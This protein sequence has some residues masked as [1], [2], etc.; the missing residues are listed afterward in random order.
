MYLPLGLK[1]I[2]P[3]EMAKRRLI[4]P[5]GKRGSALFFVMADPLNYRVIYDMAFNNR[6]R[7]SPSISDEDSVVADRDHYYDGVCS[8]D[9]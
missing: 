7:V 9:I 5:A 8:G 4:L 6:L 3:T 1:T 2:V